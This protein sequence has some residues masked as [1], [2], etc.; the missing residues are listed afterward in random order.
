MM[1]TSSNPTLGIPSEL[2][3]AVGLGHLIALYNTTTALVDQIAAGMAQTRGERAAVNAVTEEFDR[4][5]EFFSAYADAIINA[6]RSY[7]P[8]NADEIR[9]RA[10]LLLR[11]EAA[12]GELGEIAAL[13]ARLFA[14]HSAAALAEAEGRNL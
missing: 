2:L 1:M 10:W 3:G 9:A 5:G 13:A 14:D 4:L 12:R 8:E 6:A 11:H 7:E